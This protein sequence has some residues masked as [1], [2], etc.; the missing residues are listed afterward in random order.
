MRRASVTIPPLVRDALQLAG[1]VVI[2]DARM[3]ARR[4]S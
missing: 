3:D 1:I 4:S 2:A